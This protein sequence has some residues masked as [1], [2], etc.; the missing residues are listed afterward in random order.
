MGRP[1]ARRAAA[2]GAAIFCHA[3]NTESEE[4]PSNWFEHAP[5]DDRGD[6]APQGPACFVCGDYCAKKGISFQQLV[7]ASESHRGKKK[8]VLV[9]PTCTSVTVPV[10]GSPA[11]SGDHGAG[12]LGW[13]ERVTR[14][15]E[16]RVILRE[17]LLDGDT[18]CIFYV[19]Y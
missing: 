10:D 11:P 13:S 5:P 19:Y 4:N 8:G 9:S 15:I 6:M 7:Q 2:A 3:C 12:A 17:K 18:K 16:H 14:F 1:A